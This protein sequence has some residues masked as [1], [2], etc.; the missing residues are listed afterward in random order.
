MEP[1]IS[2]I[3]EVPEI[4]IGLVIAIVLAIILAVWLGHIIIAFIKLGIV[5]GKKAEHD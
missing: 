5:L 1:E 4:P 2:E 3:L